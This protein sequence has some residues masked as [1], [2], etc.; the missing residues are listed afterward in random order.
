MFAVRMCAQARTRRRAGVHSPGSSDDATMRPAAWGRPSRGGHYL[1]DDGELR[2]EDGFPIRCQ[3]VRSVADVRGCNAAGGSSAPRV[4]Y[5]ACCVERATVAAYTRRTARR[6][7]HTDHEARPRPRHS[8]TG[9]MDQRSAL[10]VPDH[11]LSDSDLSLHTQ[12]SIYIS[13]SSSP[14]RRGSM[15][16]NFPDTSMYRDRQLARSGN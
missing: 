15:P 3:F 16:M 13:S 1:A 4:L 8:H 12:G 2:G 14:G 11:F 7:L 6:L 9:A 5:A 10:F